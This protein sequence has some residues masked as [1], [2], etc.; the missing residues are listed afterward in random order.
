MPAGALIHA[1]VPHVGY[2]TADEHWR[3]VERVPEAGGATAARWAAREGPLDGALHPLARFGALL[4]TLW[5]LVHR[6]DLVPQG[7]AAREARR[8]LDAGGLDAPTARAA[9]EMVHDTLSVNR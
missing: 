3:G 8:H 9:Y 7:P 1:H 5:G 6:P 2:A 4:M